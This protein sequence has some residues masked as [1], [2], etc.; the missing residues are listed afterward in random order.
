M[1]FLIS[2]VNLRKSGVFLNHLLGGLEYVASQV[3][4]LDYT[5][6]SAQTHDE[7]VRY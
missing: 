6:A 1:N 2:G 5:K 7:E 3:D 4:K